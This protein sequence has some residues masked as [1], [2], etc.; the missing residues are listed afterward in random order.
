MVR[1]NDDEAGTVTQDDGT[2]E[3]SGDE[4]EE[5]SLSD[6]P[7]IPNNVALR[8]QSKATLRMARRSGLLSRYP[9]EVNS[10]MVDQ[11]SAGEID[12]TLD[13]A[14]ND[15][16]VVAHPSIPERVG[17]A[18]ESSHSE[19]PPIFI[20]RAI[21]PFLASAPAAIRKMSSNEWPIPFTISKKDTKEAA[22]LRSINEMLT[23]AKTLGEEFY[24]V[25]LTNH[26]DFSRIIKEGGSAVAEDRKTIKQLEKDLKKEQSGR[27]ADQ[28]VLNE[29]KFTTKLNE[30]KIRNLEETKNEMSTRIKRY[31]T[32]IDDLEKSLRK[33]I[34]KGGKP[35]ADD[36]VDAHLQKKRIDL[37]LHN[38]KQM[39]TAAL[40]D[41]AA[42]KKK[43]SKRDRMKEAS[44]LS[45]AIGGGDSSF[46]GR[47]GT[48]LDSGSDS[49][50]SV[51]KDNH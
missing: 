23:K 4:E 29:H 40:K 2:H 27:A 33:A 41:K 26:K 38:M 20:D 47:L 45:L 13:N 17:D 51:S 31:E 25:A 50:Y 46:T 48:S 18:V 12:L 36:S 49:D 24:T 32:K 3:D 6:N 39:S 21:N 42:K 28:I 22:K 5:D 1:S 34:E 7:E 30:E 9:R 10:S 8:E 37:E 19:P 11:R 14:N 16:A 15:G 35:S 43:I 44:S